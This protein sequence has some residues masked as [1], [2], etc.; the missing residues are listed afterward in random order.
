LFYPRNIVFIALPVH[1]CVYGT[2]GL[3]PNGNKGYLW[4]NA[5]V[6]WENGSSLSVLN[7]MDYPNAGPGGN[8]QGIWLFT[9]GDNDG[10]LIFHDEQHRGVKNS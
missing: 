7:G 10:G 5:R 8:S 6:I 3:Y 1:I 4:T 9:K 2:E